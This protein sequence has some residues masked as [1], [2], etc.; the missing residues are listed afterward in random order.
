M[1]SR[2]LINLEAVLAEILVSVNDEELRSG[3]S[4]GWYTSRIQESLEEISFSIFYKE[5]TKDITDYDWT[6]DGY[7]VDYPEGCMDVKEIYLFNGDCCEIETSVPVLWKRLFNRTGKKVGGTALIVEGAT[8]NHPHYQSGGD[9]GSIFYAN[10]VD[11]TI[12]FSTSCSS[13]NG[14][15]IVYSGVDSKYGEVPRIPLFLRKYVRDYV[16]ERFYFSMLVRD[17]AYYMSLWSIADQALHGDGTRRKRGSLKDA[18]KFVSSMNTF[19]RQS[20]L[21]YLSQPNI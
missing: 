7:I 17:K 21:T 5:I 11:G 19:E 1:N 20:L 13:Y 9:K 15:R 12:H 16:I 10:L 8:N 4:R 2:D 18:K 3:F 14:I 6:T